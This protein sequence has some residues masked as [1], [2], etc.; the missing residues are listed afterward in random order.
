[1]A[2]RTPLGP[3]DITSNDA[4]SAKLKTCDQSMARSFANDQTVR[5]D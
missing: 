4:T 5:I 1:L 3:G 2:T